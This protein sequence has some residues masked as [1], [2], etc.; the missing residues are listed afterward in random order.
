MPFFR[1]PDFRHILG[2]SSS[3]RSLRHLPRARVTRGGRR[4]PNGRNRIFDWDGV[5]LWTEVC[6]GGVGFRVT[7][8]ESKTKISDGDFFLSPQEREGRVDMAVNRGVGAVE[9]KVRTRDEVGF[10]SPYP[11]AAPST[12]L[13]IH[14]MVRR[15]LLKK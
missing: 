9:G 11:V 5:A 13:K 1:W 3:L 6:E 4:R 2:V 12:R 7:V 10:A 14:S 15:D 8:S